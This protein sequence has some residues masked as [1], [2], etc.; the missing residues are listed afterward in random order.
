MDAVL[1]DSRMEEFG[2]CRAV[3]PPA[4]DAFSGIVGNAGGQP[5]DYEDECYLERDSEDALK[6]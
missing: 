4:N 2:A 6:F 3:S 5:D 1:N